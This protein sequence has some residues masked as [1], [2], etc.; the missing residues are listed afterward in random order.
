M[1][2]YD[3]RRQQ[4]TSEEGCRREGAVKPQGTV[5]APSSSSAQV[6][7]SS[8]EGSNDLLERMLEGDNLRLACRRVVQNG[9]AKSPNP[10]AGFG[11]WAS[12]P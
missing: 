6:D 4:N 1:R 3:E 2:S 9:G 8:R 12:Q 7:L 11:Y 5:E 10:E